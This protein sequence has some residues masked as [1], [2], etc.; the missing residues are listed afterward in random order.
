MS[1]L[2]VQNL[3]ISETL[4]QYQTSTFKETDARVQES[5]KNP[6]PI[7]HDANKTLSNSRVIPKRLFIFNDKN[8]FSN[9]VKYSLLFAVLSFIVY[10][11]FI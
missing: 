4:H 6:V 9:Y 11:F 7:S 2:D 8:L 5:K 10:I 3:Q 1:E